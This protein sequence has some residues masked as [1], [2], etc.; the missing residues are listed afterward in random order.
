MLLVDDRIERQCSFASGPV[1]DNQLSLSPTDGEQRVHDQHPGLDRL[2][3][4]DSPTYLNYVVWESTE[5]VRVAFAHPEFV[6]K[7]S[8]Y[9]SSVVAS[10]HLFQKVAVPGFCT[11]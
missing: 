9:P 2:A 11:A 8:A 6:G 10:P 1:A 7:L 3:L 5:T 4:G